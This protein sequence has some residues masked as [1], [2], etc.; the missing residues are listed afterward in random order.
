MFH[1]SRNK[2]VD[3]D[4]ELIDSSL[5]VM[6]CAI[7]N[8]LCNLK[9]VKNTHGGELPLVIKVNLKLINNLQWVFFM[10]FEQ[11]KCQQ[12]TQSVSYEQSIVLECSKRKND[13]SPSYI[14]SYF[15]G[16][17]LHESVRIWSFFG[18]YFPASGLNTV[19]YRESLRIQFECGKIRNRKTPNTDTLFMQCRQIYTRTLPIIF[20]IEFYYGKNY[21]IPLSQLAEAATRVVL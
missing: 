10:F 18:P 17:A 9:I 14:F 3:L 12:I 7:C 15:E 6:L 2:S 19:R 5:Y 16:L 20:C 21:I 4:S 8:H 11:F 1:S 13:I